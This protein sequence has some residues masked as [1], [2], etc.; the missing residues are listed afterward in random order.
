MNGEDLNEKQKNAGNPIFI[1]VI[2]IILIGFVFFVPEIYKKY[3]KEINNIFN[4]GSEKEE[5]PNKKYEGPSPRS[6]YYQIGSKSSFTFNEITVSNV[7]LE[8]G[9]LSLT[10]SS[11]ETF[12][13][14]TSGYYVEFYKNKE[15]FIGRRSLSGIVTKSLPIE[16]DVSSLDVDTITY[17]IISRI[18]DSAIGGKEEGKDGLYV[19]TCQN[20]EETYMYEFYTKKLTKVTYKYNYT[21]DNLE[22]YASK[23]LEYQKLV[24]ANSNKTGVTSSIVENSNEFLFLTEFDYGTVREFNGFNKYKLFEK[25]ARDNIVKFKIEA[26]GFECK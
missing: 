3:D 16:L 18:E 24:S 7:H 20:K 25:D 15:T 1:L 22:D 14:N 6:A 5:D 21:S 19:L 10:I 13:L 4:I 23:L 26:E 2:F 12:D 8:N 11:D 17:F 9:I